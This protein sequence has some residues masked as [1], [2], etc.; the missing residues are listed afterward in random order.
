MVGATGDVKSTVEI[1]GPACG[2]ALTTPGRN[3]VLYC[4]LAG[5]PVH[6]STVA[7]TFR[8]NRNVGRNTWH[9]KE[10]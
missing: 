2:I 7:D 10:E 3:R 6:N 9:Y 4:P 8:S 1:R 5:R